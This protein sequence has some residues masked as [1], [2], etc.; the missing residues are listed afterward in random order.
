MQTTLKH[1]ICGSLLKHHKSYS[2]TTHLRT[3]FATCTNTSE[4][5]TTSTKIRQTKVTGF[6]KQAK[7]TKSVNEK[8]Q[9]ACLKYV[10]YDSRCLQFPEGKGFIELMQTV[11]DIGAAHRSCSA[12][13]LVPSRTDKRIMSTEKE[14]AI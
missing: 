4:N 6:C 1:K 5:V 3:H 9:Q 13:S 14:K 7:P 12:E 11:I 2:G 8:F 10:V